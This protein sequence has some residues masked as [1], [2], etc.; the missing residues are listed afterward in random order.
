M[1]NPLQK[2]A[3]SGSRYNFPSVWFAGLSEFAL[4]MNAPG[5]NVPTATIGG[6]A[7]IATGSEINSILHRFG[8]SP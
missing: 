2:S 8:S 1:L 6:V 4:A 3:Y 5:G 7:A